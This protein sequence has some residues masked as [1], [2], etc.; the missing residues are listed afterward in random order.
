M[1]GADRG[2]HRPVLL[3][4]SLEGLRVAP[5]GFYVDCTYGRG[6]CSAAILERLG[7]GGRLLAF[8]KDPEACAHAR[9]R[10]GNDPRF[11]IRRGSFTRVAEL[12]EA[13]MTGQVSGVCFDLGVS[14]PQLEDPVRGFSFMRDGPLDMRMDATVGVSAADWLNAASVGEIER[15]LKEYGEERQAAKIA[16]AISGRSSL[17]TTRDLANLVASASGRPSG[18]HPATRTFLAIRLYLNRELEDLREALAATLSLLRRG[19]RLTAVSFHSLE[20]R[21]VKRFI[22]DNAAPRRSRLTGQPLPGGEAALR[23]VGKPVRPGADEIEVN[24]RARSALLRV[25]EKT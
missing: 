5:D 16:K 14:S 20:D 13:G 12:S 1:A 2:E 7:R 9:A 24:P 17:R 8:D 4:A 25:A 11:E 21:I 23:V 15:V 18:K 10:F 6:G 19:G 22:R 3:A